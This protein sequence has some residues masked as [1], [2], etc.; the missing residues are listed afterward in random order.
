MNGDSSSDDE[1]C[2]PIDQFPWFK[3][4]YQNIYDDLICDNDT[5]G[6]YT[7]AEETDCLINLCPNTSKQQDAS[8]APKKF[9]CVA[10]S[11][12]G[13]D[14]LLREL[15]AQSVKSM[16]RLSRSTDDELNKKYSLDSL[17]DIDFLAKGKQDVTAAQ[18]HEETKRRAKVLQSARVVVSPI[19][20]LLSAGA[21]KSIIDKFL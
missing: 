10:S 16:V 7:K 21:N 13:A 19:T 18:Q 3:P 6:N 15:E 2:N 9:L 14:V 12:A 5:K 17:A 1:M 11:Q 20:A 8:N 4:G